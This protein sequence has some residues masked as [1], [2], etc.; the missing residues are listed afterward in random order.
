M[1]CV[2]GALVFGEISVANSCCSLSD[3]FLLNSAREIFE[4]VL[5]QTLITTAFALLFG[6]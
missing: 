4:S 6:I 1:F 5:H 2:S 3:I